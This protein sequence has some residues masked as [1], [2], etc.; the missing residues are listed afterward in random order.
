MTARSDVLV[1]GGGVAGMVAARRLA[2][3]GRRVR[4]LEAGPR[5]GG[6]VRTLRRDGFTADVGPDVFLVRKPGA[7]RLADALGV[8]TAPARGAARVLR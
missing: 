7:Q 4:L 1:L 5:L 8:E 2:A 3:S 6:V